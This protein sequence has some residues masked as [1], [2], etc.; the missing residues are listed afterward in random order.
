M[1]TPPF[2][3]Q[4]CCPSFLNTDGGPV[5][6]AQGEILDPDGKP[7]PGLYSAGEFGSVW[8]GVYQGGGNIAECLIFGR[9]SARSAIANA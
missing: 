8:S 4:L 5:R 3:A 6:S 2:Y 9:I 1:A 7:I